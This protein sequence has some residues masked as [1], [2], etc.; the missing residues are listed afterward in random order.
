MYLNFFG[1]SKK[2]FHITPDPEFLYLSPSHK[3]ALGSMI[4]GI[5]Q[6]MGFVAITGEVGTG[7]TTIIRSYLDNIDREKIL[8]IYIFN[9]KVTF[10]EL[11]HNIFDEVGIVPECDNVREMVNFLSM[12]LI[13][14]FKHDQN[15]ALIV[16][17]AQSMPVD[18]LEQLRLLSNIET[19]TEKL[20]Q[21]VLVGQPELDE[22]LNL[23]ELRQLRQRIAVKTEIKHLSDEESE[24]Y[25]KHRLSKVSPFGAEVFSKEALK[26][27][28]DNSMGV[29]RIINTLC[30]NALVA[31]FAYQ[32]KVVNEKIVKEVVADY[33]G[34]SVKPSAKK[35]SR[36]LKQN[37]FSAK[38]NA[39]LIIVILA[40]ICSL[41]FM[42]YNYD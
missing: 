12:M 31:A 21:V 17:E 9:A 18:T 40:I 2:P 33:S 23:Q 27:I 39:I 25:I 38:T 36:S 4:Y 6:R 13:D 42:F 20:L 14:K 32:Q 22:K 10:K 41:L 30:E 7:K 29:P 1:F 28:V 3:E 35:I 37:F 15:I 11:L 26:I 5:E 34:K 8:P 24:E 16:D 19:T